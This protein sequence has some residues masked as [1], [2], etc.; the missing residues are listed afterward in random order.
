MAQAAIPAVVVPCAGQ[1]DF[2]RILDN[3]TEAHSL[4]NFPL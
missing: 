2:V 3:H 1:V 4:I